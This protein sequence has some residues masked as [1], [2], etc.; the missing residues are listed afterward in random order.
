MTLIF[1]CETERTWN[2]MQFIIINKIDP[3]YVVSVM[4]SVALCQHYT[5]LSWPL[6]FCMDKISRKRRVFQL[7]F[8]HRFLK[9]AQFVL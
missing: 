1:V 2:P 4:L 6:P 9:K 8:I 5:L 7:F 3:G